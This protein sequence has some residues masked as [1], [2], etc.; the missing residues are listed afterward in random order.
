[1]S[2]LNQKTIK[3][4]ISINGIG[5]HTGKLVTLNLIPSAPNTGIIF[6]R[7]DLKTNN[8]VIPIYDNV[9]ETTLCTTLSNE[10]GVKVS[11]VEHLMGALYG[12]GIDNL[13][14][15]INSQELPI[16][17]GSAK[18]FIEKILSAGLKSSSTPIKLI[19]INKKVSYKDGDK[20]ISLD[21]SKVASEIDFEINYKN[22]IIGIQRNKVNVFN[23]DLKNI[24]ESRTFCLLEDV[25]KLLVEKLGMT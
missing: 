17:D 16:L 9:T 7:I 2:F 20:Y 3:D 22:K 14:V 24:F 10:Y 5:L 6:K 25:E 1:M 21:K 11:T 18:I 15:E 8:I 12:L 19:K 4:R 13:L 23:D